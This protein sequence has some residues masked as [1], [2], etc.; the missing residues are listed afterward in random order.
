MANNL[1][2]NVVEDLARIFLEKFMSSR[3]VTKTVDTQL[4][5]GRYT[6]RTGGTVSFKRPHDYNTIRTSGGDIG[7]STKSDIISGKATGVVQ[8]YFTVATEWENIEEAL[9][10]DQLDRII[11]PMAT[12]IVTDLEV[13][14]G[15][16]MQQNGG[17]A[18]GTPGT[19]VTTWS[20][21]SR[22]QA[23]ME[24]RG[25]PM[26]ADWNYVMSPFT[27]NIL[28]DVQ[29][30]LSS[31]RE[32]LVTNAW[33]RAQVSDRLAGMK[34]MRSNALKTFTSGASADRV[35]AL[36]ATPDATY[37]TAKDTMTQSLAV[38]NFTAAGTILAGD[39]IEVTGRR[40]LNLSTRET[41]V[42]NT[43]TVLLWRAVVTADVTLSGGAGTIV[44][45]GPAIRETDGQYNTV[46]SALVSGDVVTLLGATAEIRQPNLI[47][48]PQ[49]F[50][51]GTVKLPKLFSTDTVATTEDGFSIRVS[52][53]ADGDANVQKVRF[54]LLP[55]FI[56]FNPFFG[57]QAWG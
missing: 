53:Y 1:S 46:D 37:V 18:V 31:G 52:K 47:Y 24:S 50:G 38:D 14:L 48:H 34:V 51:I 19:G 25:V 36:S 35:G 2:S 56:T 23:E 9:E 45:T 11:E 42:D 20:D 7:A 5:T 26:D 41:M 13:D 12:R 30:S 44:V 17:L 32:S 16:F 43:G 33:E 4:L 21:V 49:A 28:A 10:L 29:N 6:P 8:D 3:V 57:G 54:D 40:Q 22:A 39:V 27:A 15:T 55:A